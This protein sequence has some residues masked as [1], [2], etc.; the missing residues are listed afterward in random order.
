MV[1]LHSLHQP[2]SALAGVLQRHGHVADYVTVLNI[3]FDKPPLQLSIFL[4]K[5]DDGKKSKKSIM[6]QITGQ[7]RIPA[8]RESGNLGS[9]RAEKRACVLTSFLL[10]H[11]FALQLRRSFAPP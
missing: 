9:P 2:N 11:V 1:Q 8:L 6:F 10:F 4:V 3:C 5:Q 7:I